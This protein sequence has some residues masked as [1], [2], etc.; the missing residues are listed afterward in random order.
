MLFT[1]L[2]DIQTVCWHE[3]EQNKTHTKKSW[4]GYLQKKGPPNASRHRQYNSQHVIISD[5][6]RNIFVSALFRQN[7]DSGGK[8]TKRAEHSEPCR[9]V[10]KAL[11][12]SRKTWIFALT[13]N[14]HGETLTTERN[15]EKKRS[16][17]ERKPDLC[18]TKRSFCLPPVDT[19]PVKTAVD[20]LYSRRGHVTVLTPSQ[21]TVSRYYR[22]GWM[23][24]H[25]WDDSG[26]F[27][28]SH[29]VWFLRRSL[30]V[31]SRRSLPLLRKDELQTDKSAFF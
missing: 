4:I 5:T 20:A 19:W 16:R 28:I 3:R 15:L 29:S 12:L 8:K 22:H 11:Q 7:L 31:S 30:P 14:A 17:V 6:Q 1:P 24:V 13:D 9:V 27:S 26:W 21:P 18:W 2:L 23:C 25:A 10:F